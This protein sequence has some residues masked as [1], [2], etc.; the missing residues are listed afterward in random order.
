MG[1]G[2]RSQYVLL[3]YSGRSYREDRHNNETRKSKSAPAAYPT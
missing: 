3:K 2:M 1:L